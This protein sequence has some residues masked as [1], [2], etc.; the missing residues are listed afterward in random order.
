MWLNFALKVHSAADS[1]LSAPVASDSY[2]AEAA[3][4]AVRRMMS[5]GIRTTCMY[6]YRH[7]QCRSKCT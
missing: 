4:N 1:I 5:V 7:V 6:M 2:R 3:A